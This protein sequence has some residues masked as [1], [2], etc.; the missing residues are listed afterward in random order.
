MTQNEFK[1]KKVL[2]AGGSGLI[3]RQLVKLLLE[4]GANVYISDLRA[5]D[6]EISDYVTFNEYDLT[7]YNN[8]LSSCRGMDY[9]FNLL[10]LKGSPKIMKN[11]PV[12][13]FVPQILFNTNLLKAAHECRVK[14]YLYTSSVGVYHPAEVFIED[15]V[16]KTFPSEHDRFAGWAKRMGELQAEAYRIQYGWKDISIVRPANVYGPYD[17]FDSDA[18]MVV[19]S[20][21][22]KAI[23]SNE[24]LVVWGNGRAVRDFIHSKDVARGMML[25]MQKSPGPNFPVNLAS[26]I[27]YTI[28]ELVD[29]ITNNIDKKLEVVWDTSA[30][31]GDNKRL[32]DTTRAESIGF[33][34]NISLEEGVKD[35]IGWYTEY[36]NTK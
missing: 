35:L 7:D 13:A 18:A 34:P 26:G 29:I 30:A 5:P 27:G 6:D 32:L 36:G 20:L 12:R 10:C 31:V 8:C 14:K 28:K 19:P 2:I 25:V 33:T 15:D 11:Q 9:V 24:K 4:Q 22:K 16:W 17:D 3:G 23:T 1:G 21:V